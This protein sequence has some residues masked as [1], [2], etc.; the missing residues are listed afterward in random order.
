M[1]E[2]SCAANIK[3][4]AFSPDG[5]KFAVSAGNEITV[6]NC[7]GLEIRLVS[8][9]RYCNKYMADAEVLC[10]DWSFD[11][12]FLAYGCSNSTV[13]VV[14]PKAKKERIHIQNKKPVI[15]SQSQPVMGVFFMDNSYDLYVVNK[16]GFIVSFTSSI[17]PKE[18]IVTNK[19]D[20]TCEY[21]EKD[22]KIFTLN[23]G[24][25]MPPD[26]IITD[27]ETKDDEEFVVPSLSG[28]AFHKKNEIFVN[29]FSDGRFY[30]IHAGE[31]MHVQHRLKCSSMVSE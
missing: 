20:E 10:L 31:E 27:A 25:K 19:D 22:F 6:F 13:S 28:V 18:L 8:P 24:Q 14:W 12:R 26:Y 15:N 16:V 7:D 3:N 2:K 29:T 21:A 23:F 1:S 17:Q 5:K 4:I 9:I 11:S 30:V